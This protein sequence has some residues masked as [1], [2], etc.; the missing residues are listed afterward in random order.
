[1]R[2]R[3]HAAVA[4]AILAV[5]AVAV[6]AQSPSLEALLARGAAYEGAFIGSFSNVVAEETL[7]QEMTIPRRKRTLKSDLL[8]VRY[9]G[10]TGWLMF[11]DVFEVDGKSVRDPSQAERMT[12]LFV[13]APRDAI[14]RAN[15]IAREGARYNIW[16]IGTLNHPLLA[17]V[18]LQ[19][20][21]QPRFRFNLAGIEKKLGPTVRT[22]RFQE[23]KSPTILRV[24]ANSD[25]PANGL[26]WIDETS[27]RVVKTQLRVGGLRGPEV[28]T[29]YAFDEGLGIDVPVEMTDW[30]PDG[31]GEV[32]GK[33]TYSRFRRFQVRTD[34]ATAA[35]P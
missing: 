26:I 11:R 9:P 13:D 29:T 16:D 27:G 14:S 5:A 34:E 35:Q 1:M 3:L 28:N 22:V 4:L 18:F 25:L 30:Y 23:W 7:L 6:S 20:D 2:G 17:L 19:A 10:S 24:G 31:Q 15:E 8:L 33:A 32:R 21:Y 12:K